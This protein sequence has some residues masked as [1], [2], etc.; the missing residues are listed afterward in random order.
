MKWR[1]EKR[2]ETGKQK[3]KQ[4][5][6]ENEERPDSC[7]LAQTSEGWLFVENDPKQN[8]K[9]EKGWDKTGRTNTSEHRLSW[10]VQPRRK[11]LRT[12]LSLSLTLF[13]SS[14]SYWDCRPVSACSMAAWRSFLPFAFLFVLASFKWVNCTSLSLSLS[15]S[16]SRLSLCHHHDDDC[17]L[18]SQASVCSMTAWISCASE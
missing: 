5:R 8:E 10:L 13:F 6:E 9:G 2:R 17:L 15:L 3:K 18:G 7:L 14:H 1:E 4:R 16:L 12:M 11:T